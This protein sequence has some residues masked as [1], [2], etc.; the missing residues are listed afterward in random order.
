M[1]QF[2][3][4]KCL[5]HVAEAEHRSQTGTVRAVEVCLEL[6]CVFSLVFSAKQQ[7]FIQ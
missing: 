7:I 2:L 1:I 6:V 5:M 4:I 3:E